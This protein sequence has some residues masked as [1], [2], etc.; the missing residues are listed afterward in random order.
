[1][2][3][4]GCK[5]TFKYVLQKEMHT[6]WKKTNI[7]EANDGLNSSCNIISNSAN[8]VKISEGLHLF[9]SKKHALLNS[10]KIV[11]CVIYCSLIFDLWYI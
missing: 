8:W 10:T 7:L 11:K 9:K 4:N 2:G 3:I 6:Q 1:M 5:C